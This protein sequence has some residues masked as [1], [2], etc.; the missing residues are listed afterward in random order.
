MAVIGLTFPGGPTPFEMRLVDEQTGAGVAGLRVTNDTGMVHHTGAH[1]ELIV[2]GQS[3]SR[4]VRFEIQ[5]ERNRFDNVVTTLRVTPG[6]Q[7][8]LKVRRRT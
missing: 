5:D 6:A 7:A 3:M 1:G 2:W 4:G 8:T